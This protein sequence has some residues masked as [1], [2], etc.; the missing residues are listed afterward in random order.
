M[1]KINLSNEEFYL[2]KDFIYIISNIDLKENK[3]YLIEQRLEPIL[4][5][6]SYNSFTQLIE[7]LSNPSKALIDEI[8]SAITTNETF[9]FRDVHIFLEIERVIIPR[10]FELAKTGNVTVW[11][12]ACS[13]G[14]EPYTIAMLLDSYAE[15]QGLER[16]LS[17]ISIKA[18]DLDPG[19]VQKAIEGK[20]N[21]FDISRGLPF[22]FKE[23]YFKKT[24]DGKYEII[25]KLKNM[26]R[27]YRLNLTSYALY[28]S[29]LDVI[30]CR[31]VL[32]YFDEETKMKIISNLYNSLR[33]EGC[34]ILG[35]SENLYNIK[36]GFIR[37]EHGR[38]TLY[39][40]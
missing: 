9:F 31:N 6:Y 8:I 33:P 25:S 28:P 32:I 34:I 12:A 23:K 16:F 13:T 22:E 7:K 26:I 20:Y 30:L 4:R 24:D 10:V 1:T 36:T 27:F 11:S 15:E 5:K 17:K 29:R 39:C 37:K 14:Q 19:V 38:L 2:L 21:N 3:K 40:R 18:T 35:S